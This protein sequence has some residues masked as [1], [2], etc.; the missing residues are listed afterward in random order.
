MSMVPAAF[1]A[2]FQ[3]MFAMNMNRVSIGYGS[4]FQALAMTECIMPCAAIGASQENALSMRIGVPSASTSRSSGPWVK[5][6][7]GPGIGLFGPTSPILPA[8][9]GP[10]GAGRGNGGL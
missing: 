3:L 2:E 10:G 4:P 6:S 1:I 8:G 9:F 5:P 7:G